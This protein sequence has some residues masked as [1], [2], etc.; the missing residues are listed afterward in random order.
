MFKIIFALFGTAF[1]AES[2]PIFAPIGTDF[3]AVFLIRA[4]RT[5]KDFLTATVITCK[6][7]LTFYNRSA[8]GTIFLVACFTLDDFT[9]MVA[10]DFFSHDFLLRG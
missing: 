1:F 7:S 9:A 10:G 6:V 3:L 5:C 2:L 8:L 4:A